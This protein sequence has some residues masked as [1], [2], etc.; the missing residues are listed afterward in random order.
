[1]PTLST[2]RSP[3]IHQ[4]WT[5]AGCHFLLQEIFS[6]QGS[7]LG[8]QHCRWSFYHLSHHGGPLKQNRCARVQR[9]WTQGIRR[10]DGVGVRKTYLLIDIRNIRLD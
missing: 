6:I 10:V 9:Q 3:W 1:M 4:G 7:V 5:P 8:L 2:L